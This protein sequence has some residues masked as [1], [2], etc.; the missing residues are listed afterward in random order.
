MDM[1][2]VRE[3]A[4][5]ATTRAF[6]DKNGFVPDEE[7]RRVGGGIPPSIRAGQKTA[8]DRATRR[9]QARC[10]SGAAAGR[11][12]LGELTG[13]PT[14]IRWAAALRADRLQEVRDLEIR[15]WLATTWTRAKKLDRHA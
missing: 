5:E 11:A 10:G 14:Q 9:G 15:D 13:A 12:R 1:K 6:W 8:R 7:Q 4:I 3:E 2:V